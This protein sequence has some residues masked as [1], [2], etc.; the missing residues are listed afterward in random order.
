MKHILYFHHS[1]ITFLYFV[2]D[3]RKYSGKSKK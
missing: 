2:K 1:L 3:T